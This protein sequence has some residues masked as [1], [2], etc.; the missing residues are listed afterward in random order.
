MKIKLFVAENVGGQYNM[1]VWIHDLRARPSRGGLKEHLMEVSIMLF[2]SRVFDFSHGSDGR[3][4]RR[5]PVIRY[6]RL[7]SSRLN[8]RLQDHT[9]NHFRSNVESVSVR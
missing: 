7:S 1:K 8:M 4:R 2:L 5:G 9:R 6:V 3:L